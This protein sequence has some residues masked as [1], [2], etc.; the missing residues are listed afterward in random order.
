MVDEENVQLWCMKLAQTWH[1]ILTRGRQPLLVS[2]G[3]ADWAGSGTHINVHYAH[4]Y[5]CLPT[6][7]T[8]IGTLVLLCKSELR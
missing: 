2:V 5:I 3:A 8:H 6:L 7:S 1:Y 4:Q